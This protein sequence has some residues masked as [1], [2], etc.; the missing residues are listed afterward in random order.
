MLYFMLK[1][2][3]KLFCEYVPLSDISGFET[4]PSVFSRS[5]LS[6][7]YTLYLKHGFH[8]STILLLSLLEKNSI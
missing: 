1:L 3:F 7:I 8:V 5:L 6:K 4:Q 2:S